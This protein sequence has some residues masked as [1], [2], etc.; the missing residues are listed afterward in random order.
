[1]TISVLEYE[2]LPKPPRILEIWKWR[3]LDGTYGK[4]ALLANKQIR[5]MASDETTFGLP[6]G[7]WHF[8]SYLGILTIN[9]R[10]FKYVFNYRRTTDPNDPTVYIE[11]FIKNETLSDNGSDTGL[12]EPVVKPKPPVAIPP[13]IPG[14][15]IPDRPPGMPVPDKPIC[16]PPVIICPP[17]CMKCDENRLC[18]DVKCEPGFITYKKKRST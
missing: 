8:D 12:T 1:M 17:G 6:Q 4:I 14:T 2:P 10:S 18:L 11:E 7:D 15:P 5:W 3:L 16:P 13:P 9:F